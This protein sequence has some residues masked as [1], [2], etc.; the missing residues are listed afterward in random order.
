MITAKRPIWAKITAGRDDDCEQFS[1]MVSG[2]CPR[3]TTGVHYCGGKRHS[4]TGQPI[5]TALN[6]NGIPNMEAG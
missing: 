6:D 2:G 5:R 4:L 3:T 1:G